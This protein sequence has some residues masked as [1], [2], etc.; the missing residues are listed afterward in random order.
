[1]SN[2]QKYASFHLIVAVAAILAALVLRLI[3]ATSAAYLAG[4]SILGL[5]G[6]GEIHFQ[7]SGFTPIEDERDQQINRKALMLAYSVFWVCFVG[8]SVLVTLVFS[9]EGSISTRY[10]E[11]V[12]WLA[13]C[14]VTLVHSTAVLVLYGKDA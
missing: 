7:R 8:W 4:F 1:M 6:L 5:L 2:L 14:L 10:V 12:V 3:P 13:F 9:Q 11:P